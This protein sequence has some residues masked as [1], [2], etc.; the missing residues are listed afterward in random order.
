MEEFPRGVDVFVAFAVFVIGWI[1]AIATYGFFLGGG[2]GWLPAACLAII[3]MFLWRVAAGL[4]IIAA[5][6]IALLVYFAR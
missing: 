1:Y 4:A 6:G 2:L 5:A 3:A